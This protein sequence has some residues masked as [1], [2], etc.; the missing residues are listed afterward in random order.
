M[1]MKEHFFSRLLGLGLLAVCTVLV[2]VAAPAAT[3]LIRMSTTPALTELVSGLTLVAGTSLAVV[4][5]ASIVILAL[6][7]VPKLHKGRRRGVY[8]RLLDKKN[9]L[10]GR[11]LLSSL[12]GAGN[13]LTASHNR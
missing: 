6:H 11:Q 13:S 7:P 5:A 8:R 10:A 9:H 1:K 12:G 3:E 4:S 2:M